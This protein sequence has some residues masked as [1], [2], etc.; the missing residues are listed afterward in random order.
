MHELP[1]TN[2]ILEI[3]LNFA[4]Q[5][6]ANEIKQIN[7]TIGSLSDIEDI[8][9]NNFFKYISRDTIAENA[10]LKIRRTKVK[11]L[12]H[13]CLKEFEQE[14]NGKPPLCPYCMEDKDL[15]LISGREFFVESIAI[16]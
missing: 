5:N 10:Q 11:W 1:L 15:T 13:S 6:N 4:T 7:I 8:W 3:A 9:L 2:R 16:I 14:Q 12:C